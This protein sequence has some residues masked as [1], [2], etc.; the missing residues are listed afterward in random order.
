MLEC[1]EL[2]KVPAK[3]GLS[4]APSV[5]RPRPTLVAHVVPYYPPHLGGMEN[6]ASALA[7]GFA[8]R[9][10]VVVLTSRS[11]ARN[12]LR[13][14][15]SEGLV[16]RRLLTLEWEHLPFMPTLLFHLLLLPRRAIVHVHIAQA[17]V[18]EMVWLASLVRRRPFIAH[19]HLDVEASGR[20]GS[21]FVAYK[22]Y[23]LG[24]TLR[25]AAHVIVL[26]A[27]QALFVKER[28]GIQESH[29]SIIP[30]GVAPELISE[31]R[32]RAR[33]K[34]GPMHLLFVGRLSPQKN[35]T[36]LLAAMSQ[37]SARVELKIVGDGEDR[38][39]LEK[40]R[41]EFGLNNVVLVGAQR[42]KDLIACYQWADAFVLPSTKEGMPL[43]ILE[44]MA[45]G[46]PIIATDVPGI[47][48]TVGCNGMLVNPNPTALAVAIDRVA[49]DEALRTE[50]ARKSRDQRSAHAWPGVL[51]QIEAVY[52]IVARQ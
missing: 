7:E 10:S 33:P 20:F 6:V 43:V 52:G 47:R 44:A 18:P 8:T 38:S 3:T 19:F 16:V 14:E 23:V 15:R 2:P 27:D 1:D 29:I 41:A 5:S 9:G 40:L 28:Y 25:A 31:C 32:F 30:N 46:L 39:K 22:R 35:L 26:S 21:V 42:G 34:D 51:A 17:Y 36:C 4:K 24:R 45:A 12:S 49:T 13:V 50:L 37:L 11:G 48:D